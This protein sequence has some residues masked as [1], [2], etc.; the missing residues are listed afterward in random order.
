MYD[1]PLFDSAH[2]DN[3][4]VDRVH[5]QLENTFFSMW[6]EFGVKNF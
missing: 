1:V 2:S 6:L 5:L 3:I 4:H